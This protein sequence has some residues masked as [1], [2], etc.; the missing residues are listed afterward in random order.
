MALFYMT[1]CMA[2][3]MYSDCS[4]TDCIRYSYTIATHIMLTTCYRYSLDV[5]SIM[6]TYRHMVTYYGNWY[7]A[8]WLYD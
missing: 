8:M 2:A 1:T 7:I 3:C 4:M 5:H 6:Y